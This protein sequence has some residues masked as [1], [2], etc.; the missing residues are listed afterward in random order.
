MYTQHVDMARSGVNSKE[1][2]LTPANVNMA[3]FGKLW[4]QPVDGYLYT[5]PLYVPKVTIPGKGMHNVIYIATM[6]DTVYALDAD[7]MQAPLWQVSFLSAGVT[8]I[9]ELP[10]TMSPTVKPLVG[11]TGTPVIDPAT[12]TMYLVAATKDTTVNPPTYADRLHALDITTGAEKLGG[13]IIITAS[14]AGTGANNVMSPAGQVVYEPLR[15]LQRAGLAL[16]NGVVYIPI[17]GNGDHQH[18]HGWV[19]GYDATTLAQKYVYC[20]TPDSEGG[21]IWMGSAGIPVDSSGNLYVETGN[22]G[23]WPAVSLASFNLPMGGR[24][25]SMSLV[26]LDPTAK[27]MD[28]FAP[29]D[30]AALSANDVDLGSTGPLILPDSFSVPGHPHLMIGAGKPGYL[31]VLD[32]DS[33]GHISGGADDTQIVQKVTVH[34]N[35]TDGQ[36]GIF[37][38]PIYW[39]GF[40][41]TSAANYKVTAFSVTNGVLST[42]PSS[43]ALQSF[44]TPGGLLML[45]A[46]GNT[47]GILWSSEGMGYQPAATVH[48]V[49]HAYDALDLSKE[50]W[51]SSQNT[52]MRDQ[53]GLIAKYAMP[54]IANGRVYFG[55][56]TELEVYGL[57]P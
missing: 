40:V 35:T 19:L 50:L 6:N 33:L 38:Q 10:D 21:S 25:A 24:D 32:R 53:A 31:Y 43:Q 22:G 55:S 13:P 52:S 39:N 57:L 51:N 7:S 41:Y 11:V 8:A 27:M 23:P 4:A 14:I 48:A 16:S 29:H 1:T 36:G 34:V 9:P 5:Q 37:T 12:N 54:T 45:S 17:G 18:W 3:K 49:L 30:A 20:T 28:W 15:E 26:K 42:T 44:S 2:I 46:N 47:A 56:Q